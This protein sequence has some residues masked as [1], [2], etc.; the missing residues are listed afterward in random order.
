MS[1]HRF[2]AP[3]SIVEHIPAGPGDNLLV[4]LHGLGDTHIKYLEFG[5]R[6][7][8]PSTSVIAL[9]AE[10]PLGKR[11]GVGEGGGGRT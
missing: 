4:L 5:K 8:L 6:L 11:G 9:R 7:A 10:L 3:T 2:H 1:S